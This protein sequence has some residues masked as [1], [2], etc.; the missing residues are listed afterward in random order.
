MND[1]THITPLPPAHQC[2]PQSCF[3]SSSD[4]ERERDVRMP[5]TS[6]PRLSAY[7]RVVPTEQ[8]AY[9]FLPSSASKRRHFLE[10]QLHLHR[11]ALRTPCPSTTTRGP[12]ST[13][14]SNCARIA[15]PS[16][17]SAHFRQVTGKPSPLAPRSSL[18]PSLPRPR[19]P[20][21]KSS[22]SFQHYC[23]RLITSSSHHV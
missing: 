14:A 10:H 19:S 16:A 13:N 18:A 15:S 8:S 5:H 17:R 11:T 12:F 22:T 9:D 3:T 4:D 6:A 1:P 23:A 20:A 7:Y 2:V 21:C